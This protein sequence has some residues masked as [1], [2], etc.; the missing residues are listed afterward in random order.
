M[1]SS[2]VICYNI[3]KLT[4]LLTYLPDINKLNTLVL[5]CKL[6]LPDSYKYWSWENSKV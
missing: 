3:N 6:C 4:Y 2:S 1:K 5:Q